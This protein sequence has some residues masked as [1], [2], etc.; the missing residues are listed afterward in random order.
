VFNNYSITPDKGK[1]AQNQ[2]VFKQ[3]MQQAPKTVFLQLCIV[4]ITHVAV[5]QIM[6]RN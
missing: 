4:L 3:F 2:I 6:Q 5:K 1:G